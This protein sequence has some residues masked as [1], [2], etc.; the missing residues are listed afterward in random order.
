MPFPN[1][2][3]FDILTRLRERAEINTHNQFDPSCGPNVLPSL[4]DAQLSILQQ[5]AEQTAE[6]AK[7]LTMT[8]GQLSL[9]IAQM[10]AITTEVDRLVGEA[11]REGA[12]WASVANAAGVTPQSAHQRWKDKLQE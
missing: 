1:Q 10:K 11:R 7:S 8:L 4:D 5:E 2:S 6:N 3:I 9:R 12:S